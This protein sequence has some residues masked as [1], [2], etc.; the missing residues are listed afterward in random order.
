MLIV[1]GRYFVAKLKIAKL[2]YNKSGFTLIEAMIAS[3]ILA[4]AAGAIL[5][6]FTAGA[7]NESYA[8]QLSLAANL[9]N[10][11]LEEII[12]SEYDDVIQ[13]YNGYSESMGAVKD[14]SGNVIASQEYTNFSRSVSC[15]EVYLKG[16][17]G[18]STPPAILVEICVKNDG[19]VLAEISGLKGR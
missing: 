19:K 11:M 6:S 13:N 10:N 17:S 16:Q 9:A 12:A 7:A 8:Q 3:V 5:V 14:I 18:S 1:I 4:A 2:K 15:K